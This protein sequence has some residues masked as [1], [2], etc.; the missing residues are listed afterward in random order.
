MRL[1]APATL[2]LHQA[3]FAPGFGSSL[4]QSVGPGFEPAFELGL[5]SPLVV[6]AA[7]SSPVGP[8]GESTG[9]RPLPPGTERVENLFVSVGIG[10]MIL[11]LVSAIVIM[12][13]MARRR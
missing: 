6:R 5:G 10:I 9:T 8:D 13:R 11:L 2:V 4:E 12:V 1:T 7:S 3:R